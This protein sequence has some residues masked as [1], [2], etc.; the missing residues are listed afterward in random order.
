[1][2]YKPEPIQVGI[3]DLAFVQFN[4]AG[5]IVAGDGL[6]KSGNTLSVNVELIILLKSASDTLRINSKCSWKWFEQN[7]GASALSV[8][9][10]GTT[11]TVGTGIKVIITDLCVLTIQIL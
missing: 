4:G 7:G 6:S 1:M 5:Q 11:I 2:Y 3:T 8:Q 10:D 9:N